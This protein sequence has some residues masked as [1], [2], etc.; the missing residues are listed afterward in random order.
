MSYILVTDDQYVELYKNEELVLYCD[1]NGR[2]ED[3]SDCLADLLKQ[4][5]IDFISVDSDEYYVG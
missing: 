4:N 2:M 3:L 1:K 5:G